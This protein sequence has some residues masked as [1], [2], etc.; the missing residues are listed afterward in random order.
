MVSKNRKAHPEKINL[1][2]LLRLYAACFF[3]FQYNTNIRKKQQTNLV[4]EERFLKKG[5]NNR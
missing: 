3:C 2:G 1:D 5:A 4:Q